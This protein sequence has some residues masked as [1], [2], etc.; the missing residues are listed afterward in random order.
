M[1]CFVFVHLRIKKPP[2]SPLEKLETKVMK[3]FLFSKKGM[4]KANEVVKYI[5]LNLKYPSAYAVNPL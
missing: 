5:L 2:V 4:P 1:H 3:K